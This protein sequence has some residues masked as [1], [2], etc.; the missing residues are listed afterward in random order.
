MRRGVWWLLVGLL[1]LHGSSSADESW[2]NC[3][4]AC[5]CKWV[6]GRKV[7]ECINASLT[8]IPAN[9][10]S[11]IQVL[12]LSSN[13]IGTLPA[14]A[15]KTVG[16]VNLHKIFLKECG[17]QD[18]DK[19]AFSGL[20]ILIELDL[21]WNSI[22]LLHPLTFHDNVRLR[23]LYLNRNH[24]YKLEDG[25]FN[26]LTF[27]QTV[28]VSE[29]RLTYIGQKTFINLPYLRDL[30]L[31]RN[32][33][34]N[35]KLATLEHLNSLRSLVLYSNP[36]RCDCHLKPFLDWTINK[37]LYTQP[38]ACAEPEFL[39]NRLWNELTTD[40]LACKPLIN[41]HYPVVQVS[42]GNATLHCQA[43]G[44]PVPDI[45]W[46]FN[47]RIIGNY[48]RRPYSD[49]KRKYV[50]MES[51]DIS[52][53]WLNLTVMNVQAQDSGEYTCVA[54]SPG[55]MEERNVSLRVNGA[56]GSGG[57]I[58]RDGGY[59]H[60]MWAL[61]IGLIVGAVIILV[62]I[63]VVLI[64]CCCRKKKHLPIKKNPSD[65]VS[66]NGDIS[67][68]QGSLSEE[69]SLLTVV[70]P[71][72]KPPRRVERPSVTSA[73]TELTNLTC[74]LL[75][76]G[77]AYQPSSVA[78]SDDR[79]ED[80]SVD[81]IDTNPMNK[82][83][84]DQES[85]TH[86]YPPDLLSFPIRGSQVSPA[87]STTST[88]PDSTRLPTQHG[89]Q[90]PIHSPIYHPHLYG[91]LPYSR[92]QSPFSTTS[93]PVVLPRSQ[94]YVTIPRRPRV[95]SWSSGPTPTPTGD[96]LPFKV[97]PVYDN[98]GPRTTA[99]GSSV[100]S[101]NKSV[102][103]PVNMRSR[104]LPPT[105]NYQTLPAYYAPIHEQGMATTSSRGGLTPPS[106]A[107]SPGPKLERNSWARVAPDGASLKNKGEDQTPPN[108]RNSASSIGNGSVKV[109]PKPPPKPK[110]KSVD[111]VKGPLFEDEG[112]DGTEV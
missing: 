72:Q 41:V 29:C 92:S 70:N 107:P 82:S 30:K 25:L 39:A 31:N 60:D 69:K 8:A 54:K 81:S 57:G 71:V 21:S 101:L 78:D 53:R 112:E 74:N 28:D 65:G 33:L 58:L 86:P 110:K 64:F 34:T 7:A 100:L 90:S 109:P 19:H 11:E 26:N 18:V 22:H 52:W 37:N 20:E 89:P 87:G 79:L 35:M 61:I 76:N 40:D 2:T 12:D 83:Q 17:I 63:L 68:P 97:E 15:F 4:A 24:L 75:D 91:T 67:C 105:P 66:S 106:P 43:V 9:L 95:P 111:T 5:K 59:S 36:W 55:G 108:K 51:V 85:D 102:D 3:P 48:T 23:Q 13:N 38:T 27:L 47:S 1:F 84:D 88:A 42:S 6:S 103:P 49:D 104:P 32:N 93:T 99:D 62:L 80:H 45:H 94:G 44:N 14:N 16:L 50:M 56:M 46:V 96:P 10:S 73:G 98:L 77:S